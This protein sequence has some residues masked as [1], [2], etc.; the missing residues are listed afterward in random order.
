MW[1]YF[2]LLVIVFEIAAD[3]MSKEWSMNAQSWFLA[4]GLVFYL[5]SNLA[6]L[7]SLK[8]GSGLARGIS[9]FSVISAILAILSAL[10]FIRNE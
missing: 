5:A 7:F 10:F 4:G 9:I 8:Y 6:W 1:I 3:V 2:L